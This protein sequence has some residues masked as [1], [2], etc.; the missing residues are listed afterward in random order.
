MVYRL[1]GQ[2]TDGGAGVSGQPVVVVDTNDSDPAN[3]TVVA[4]DTTD[5]SG[6]WSATVPTGD[7]ERYHAVAQFDDGST[8]KKAPS[9]PFLTAEPVVASA[10][11]E[12]QFDVTSLA[13]DFAAIPDS[14]VSRYTF[15]D[16]DTNNGTATDVWGSN[17]GTINGAT[18][19]V[20]GAGQTYT[21]NEAYDFDGTDDNVDIPEN[22]TV[23]GSSAFSVATW[24]NPDVTDQ[25]III[26][27]GS[28][29]QR[30]H[31]GRSSQ[32]ITLYNYD[33]NNASEVASNTDISTGSWAHIVVTHN[34]GSVNFY[35]DGSEDGSGSVQTDPQTGVNAAIGK[36][37]HDNTAHY[38]GSVDDLRIYSKELSSTEVSDLYNTGSI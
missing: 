33:G 4:G 1:S 30:I 19:G 22:F 25:Q 21:T 28:H 38:D 26:N 15:D 2:M 23:S 35:L 36:N 20:T 16:A 13:S 7:V 5:G 29:D 6:N 17:D 11:A 32:K 31:Y 24:I 12:L 37:I 10:G 14:G 3:W 34:S 9:K 27:F 8:L 18:T